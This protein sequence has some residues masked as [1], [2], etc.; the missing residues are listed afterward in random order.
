M[1]QIS[2]AEQVQVGLNMFHHGNNSVIASKASPEMPQKPPLW[3]QMSPCM[4]PVLNVRYPY[5]PHILITARAWLVENHGLSSCPQLL[6]PRGLYILLIF[7]CVALG[8]CC[9]VHAGVV[10]SGTLTQL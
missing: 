10:R 4:S 7:A 8:P 6:E 1:R 2:Y 9:L 5:L 3:S